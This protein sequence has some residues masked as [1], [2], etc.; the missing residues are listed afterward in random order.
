[1]GFEIKRRFLNMYWEL[2][3]LFYILKVAPLLISIGN[4]ALLVMILHIYWSKNRQIQLKFN[5]MV[6]FF[7]CFMIQNLVFAVYFILNLPN[8]FNTLI[9]PIIFLGFEFIALSLLLKETYN[10][11]PIDLESNLSKF[12]E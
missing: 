3:L 4:L 6:I 7:T 5:I 10:D 2:N 12:I 9:S 1:M 8:N 11:M